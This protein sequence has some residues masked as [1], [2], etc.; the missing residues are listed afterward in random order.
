MK[1]AWIKQENDEQNFRA[2]EK[3]GIPVERIQDPEQIDKTIEE[4]RQAHKD[5][6][7]ISNELA[8]FSEDIIKKYQKDEEIRIIIGP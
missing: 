1:I 8:G 2:I 4:L 7:I 5:T 6:I 3:L